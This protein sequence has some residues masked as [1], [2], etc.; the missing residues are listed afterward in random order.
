MSG[1]REGTLFKV[2][3]PVRRLVEGLGLG[4]WCCTLPIKMIS[5]FLFLSLTH[6]LKFKPAPS[7]LFKVPLESSLIHGHTTVSG[8]LPMGL[9]CSY[10]YFFESLSLYFTVIAKH[11]LNKEFWM[12]L[13]MQLCPIVLQM[14][15][16]EAKDISVSFCLSCNTTSAALHDVCVYCFAS[17]WASLEWCAHKKAFILF[18][19]AIH[20]EHW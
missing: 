19:Y 5:L 3:G 2:G 1:E 8:T 15:L 11:P 6:Q 17:Q 18:L 7:F 14:S 10:F 12:L 16:S 13:C 4:D 9:T 20:K